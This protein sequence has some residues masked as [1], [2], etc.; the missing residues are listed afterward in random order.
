MPGNNSKQFTRFF[1]NF[2]AN[3]K[4]VSLGPKRVIETIISKKSCF[5]K[6]VWPISLLTVECDKPQGTIYNSPQ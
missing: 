1:H 3:D 6:K 4:I 5:Q 2:C